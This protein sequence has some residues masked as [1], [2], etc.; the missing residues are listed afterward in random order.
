MDDEMKPWE[1]NVEDA[2]ELARQSTAAVQRLTQML[3]EKGVLLAGE[4]TEIFQ[5]FRPDE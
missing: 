2:T 4:S 5:I 3:E 1:P